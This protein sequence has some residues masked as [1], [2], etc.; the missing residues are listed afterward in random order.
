MGFGGILAAGLALHFIT[1]YH[2]YKC[3]K[4]DKTTLYKGHRYCADCLKKMKR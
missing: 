2:C 3:G 1:G 4:L